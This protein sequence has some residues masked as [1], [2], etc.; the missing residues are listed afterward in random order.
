M[1]SIFETIC[2]FAIILLFILVLLAL[3]KMIIMY[4]LSRYYMRR[5]TNKLQWKATET[6]YSKESRIRGLVTG[7][8]RQFKLEWRILPSELPLII[9]AY[10]SN[11]WEE[12]K[13]TRYIEFNDEQ[14][15]KD[16]VSKFKTLKDL[17]KYYHTVDDVT[18]WYEP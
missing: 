13:A 2:A 7:N 6:S 10:G 4:P 9:K 12:F 8:K 18:V 15:F 5:P 11:H 3:I 1:E 14:E 16:F 17:K